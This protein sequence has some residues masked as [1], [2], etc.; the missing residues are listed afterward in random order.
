MLKLKTLTLRNFGSVG[1]V[2]QVIKLANNDL[3]LLFGINMDVD[4]AAGNVRNGAGK[5]TVAHAIN[6]VLYG[7][8][9]DKIKLDNLCNKINQKNMLVTLDFERDGIQYRIERGRKP[10]V[11]RYF[12]NGDEIKNDGTDSTQ[13]SDSKGENKQTMADILK[14]LGM[15][16][17]LSEQIVTVNTGS[18]PFIQKPAAEQRAIIEELL[19]ITT[20][21]KRAESL[22]KIITETKRSIDREEATVKATNEANSRIMAAV[23]RAELE[24]KAWETARDLRVVQIAEKVEASSMD[25]DAEI[26]KF[27]AVD[28]WIEQERELSAAIKEAKGEVELLTKEIHRIDAEIAAVLKQGQ[29][30]STV[31][32]A[33]LRSDLTRAKSERTADDPRV[34]QYQD[35]VARCIK[36]AATDISTKIDGLRMDISRHSATHD[37]LIAEAEKL[38][39]ELTDVDGQIANPGEHNCTTCGQALNGTEHMAEVMKTLE[40]KA[41]ALRTTIAKKKQEAEAADQQMIKVASEIEVAHANAIAER[42]QWNAKAEELRQKIAA[43]EA[44]AE[45]RQQEAEQKIAAIEV[46][47]AEAE[48]AAATKAAENATKAES[49]RE[50][51]SSLR[52][53]VEV[54]NGDVV[55]LKA[56]LESLGGKPRTSFSTRDDVWRAKQSLDTLLAQLDAEAAKENPHA[57]KVESLKAT[58]VEPDYTNLNELTVR[59]KHEDF[60]LKLLTNKDSFVRKKIIDQNL[61]FLNGRI[62]HYL[63]ELG[64]PHQVKI[65]TDLSID[66]TK[67]GL[68]YDYPQMSRGQRNR[69]IIAISWAFRDVW[70]DLNHSVNLMVMDEL[71]DFGMDDHGGEKAIGLMRNMAERGRNVILMTNK[72]S[73]MGRFE[74]TLCARLHEN[75]TTFEENAS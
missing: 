54:R 24:C 43:V 21:S 12:V 7:E 37:R 13:K 45:T 70:E 18:I 55:D 42:D 27:D 31:R 10:N 74:H 25:F 22:K 62:G 75:F 26:A 57:E 71:L 48:A 73:L 58:I 19:G 52:D 33:R 34:K 14:V 6:Y 2:T 66:I 53:A 68:D 69:I 32:I 23:E 29:T 64:L 5:T 35:E 20:L 41:V 4:D 60:L 38:L 51:V 1:N 67:D 46:E 17:E 49:L 40:A 72:E 36:M 39:E 15:S 65:M 16:P 11:L 56:V 59:L 30:D 47:I 28:A 8:P 9:L 50:E 63:T 44:E 3:T 61:A